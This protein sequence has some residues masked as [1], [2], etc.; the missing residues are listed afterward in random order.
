MLIPHSPFASVSTHSEVPEKPKAE[1]VSQRHSMAT[2]SALP[3]EDQDPLITV[4][5]PDLS[6]SSQSISQA[7][8]EPDSQTINKTV[9]QYI[10][11][12]KDGAPSCE[13]EK[14]WQRIQSYVPEQARER[15]SAQNLPCA[16]SALGVLCFG[17]V[18]PQLNNTLQAAA[19]SS[20]VQGTQFSGAAAM[21]Q[22]LSL[23]SLDKDFINTAASCRSLALARSSSAPLCAGLADPRLPVSRLSAAP[24]SKDPT[25]DSTTLFG[26]SRT[27]SP[28]QQ[29][30]APLRGFKVRPSGSSNKCTL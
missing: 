5:S 16:T 7:S 3:T 23:L 4:H 25:S 26:L 17:T 18:T 20:T 19:L 28:A 13:L 27:E 9:N 1:T 12:K 14:I 24:M 10:Q 2:F 8:T 6:Q 29:D 30:S 15:P 22:A 11:L 21:E